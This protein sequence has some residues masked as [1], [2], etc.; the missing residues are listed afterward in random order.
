MIL[1]ARVEAVQYHECKLRHWSCNVRVQTPTPLLAVTL[2]K[3]LTLSGCL[4]TQKHAGRKVDS[5]H[6]WLLGAGERGHK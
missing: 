3:L 4:H 1:R 5:L 6:G 2:G